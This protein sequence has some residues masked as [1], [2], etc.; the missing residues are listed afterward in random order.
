MH[1]FSKNRFSQV[2]N[3]FF[4]IAVLLNIVS[5]N[6]VKSQ[7]WVEKPLECCPTID[8]YVQYS[9]Y[10]YVVSL[11][12]K[13]CTMTWRI[14][15]GFIRDSYG[16]WVNEIL[17]SS[18]NAVTVKWINVSYDNNNKIMPKGKIAVMFLGTNCVSLDPVNVTIL[19]LNNFPPDPFL[20]PAI[21]DSITWVYGV[22]PPRTTLS[23]PKMIFPNSSKNVND[24]KWVI[25]A[26]ITAY[27]YLSSTPHPGP[28][29]LFTKESIDITTDACTSGE[30]HTRPGA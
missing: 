23:I 4:V 21:N 11:D 2:Q 30:I 1:T 9:L 17:N 29:E 3:L 20:Y 6:S 24:Y 5:I 26:G 19:S 7:T 13:N 16:N 28:C 18:L 27:E 8:D 14:E 12:G 15:N 22:T 10:N 25:P